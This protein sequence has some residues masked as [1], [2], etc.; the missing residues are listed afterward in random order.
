MRKPFL[1]YTALGLMLVFAA[2][3]SVAHLFSFYWI[4]W[5]YDVMMHLWAGFSGGLLVLWFFEPY[6]IGGYKSFFTVIGCLFVVG[7]VWEIFEYYNNFAQPV[8]YGLDTLFDFINDI[9]GAI[10]AFFYANVRILKS[11]LGFQ[12]T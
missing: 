5:W 2:L 10:L 6:N 9:L 1:L 12:D 11:S 7:A 4:Y 3:D 8:D